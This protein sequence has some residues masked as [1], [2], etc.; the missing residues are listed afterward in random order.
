MALLAMRRFLSGGQR[1][2]RERCNRLVKVG[3][4][5]G[6]LRQI[7][8]NVHKQAHDIRLRH[9]APSRRIR[10]FYGPNIYPGAYSGGSE[11]N[12]LKDFERRK[13]GYRHSGVPRH[14]ARLRR[15]VADHLV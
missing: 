15:M 9:P 14:A 12:G 11:Q 1:T 5:G 8:G 2:Y 3:R 4:D 13:A 7:T 10:R 6:R